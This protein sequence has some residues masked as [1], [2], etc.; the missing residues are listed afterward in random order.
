[1]DTQTLIEILQVSIAPV[2]LISGVGL[3]LLTMTNRLGRVMDR[4]RVLA[5]NL[6][7]LQK[8]TKSIRD[9][10]KA[11]TRRAVTLRAAIIACVSS[12]LFSTILILGLFLITFFNIAKNM[13]ITVM[14]AMSILSLMISIL[15]FIQD[16]ILSLEA[17]QKQMD[18]LPKEA[19]L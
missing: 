15:F 1:M 6:C 5:E 8:S 7:G 12:V 14:F 10:I 16:I 18:D 4:S 2:A 17:Y 3:L 9:Q 19:K 11:M 13:F